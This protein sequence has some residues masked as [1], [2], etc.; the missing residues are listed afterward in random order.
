MGGVKGTKYLLKIRN[1]ALRT[2]ENQKQ[3]PSAFL[4]KG[5]GQKVRFKTS[6]AVH[7]YRNGFSDT[8]KYSQ[9]TTRSYRIRHIPEKFN[10]LVDRLLRLNK[11]LNTEWSLDQMVANC[12]FQMLIFPD[13]NLF[14]TRFSHKLPLCVSPVLDN[15]SSAI[16]ALSMNWN[17]FHAYKCISTNSS[18]TIYSHQNLSISV[19]NSSNCSSLA[20]MSLVLRG[21]TTTSMSPDSTSILSNLTNTSNGKVSTSK[22]PNSCPSHLGVIKQWIRDKRFL[23]NVAD[24]VSKSRKASTQRVYY[25]KWIIYSNWCHRKKVNLVSASLTIIADFLIYHFSE[26]KCQIS[27]IKGYRSMISYSLKFK[28]GNR[29]GSHPVLSELIRSSELQSCP[30]ISYPETGFILGLNLSAKSPKQLK[31]PFY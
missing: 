8:T 2:T 25:A 16:N 21:V 1:H 28:S 7:L 29:I 30:M 23:Q 19:Q 10:I 4:Q 18:D 3:C 12:I 26:K 14:A 9:S 27:T 24:F 13:V 22:P 15:H 31:L 17:N 11:P 6:S 5:G 20:S